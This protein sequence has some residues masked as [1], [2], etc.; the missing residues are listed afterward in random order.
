ML[1]ISLKGTARGVVNQTRIDFL[2]TMLNN[3]EAKMNHIDGLRQRNMNIAAIIFAAMYSFGLHPLGLAIRPLSFGALMLIMVV[4]S[5]L[6]RRLHKFQHGWRKTRRHFVETLRDVINQPNDD[7]SF[8]RYYEEGEKESER[9][10]LQPVL[11]YMLTIAAAVS[12]LLAL[13]RAI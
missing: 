12:L 7:V 3:A 8:Q 4:F 13:T 6:D 5:L 9:F 2:T 11:Y 1:K 10:A